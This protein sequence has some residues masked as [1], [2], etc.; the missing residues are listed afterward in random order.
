M[1][2]AET[3]LLNAEAAANTSAFGNFARGA[4][5][6]VLPSPLGTGNPD[7]PAASSVVE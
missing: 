4:T 1:I 5:G 2:R 7:A 3:W 6:K